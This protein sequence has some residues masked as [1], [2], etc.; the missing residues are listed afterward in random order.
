MARDRSAAAQGIATLLTKLNDPDPD[1]RFMQLSDLSNILHAPASEYIKS[2][3]HTAARIIEGLLK[4]LADQHGEVQNQALKCVGPLATR[5]PGEIMAPL[6]DKVTNLTDSDIDISIPN[7]ALRSL[8]SALPQ[9]TSAGITGQDVKDAYGAV[10]KVLIPRLVGHVILPSMKQ[11]KLPGTGLLQQQKDKGFSSDAVDV[12]IEIVRCYGPLLQEQEL[13]ELAKAVMNIIESP[14]A[15]GVVKKR[16]LAGMGALIVHFSDAQVTSFVNALTQSFQNPDITNEH[17]KYLVSTIGT[18]AKSTPAKF[19]PHLHTTAAY[20]LAPLSQGELN[21]NTEDSDADGEV[22]PELEELRETALIAVEA[23]VGSCP[24]E[25][26]PHVPE[27][28][29]AALRYLKYDPNVATFD[30]EEMGGTQDAG[31]DDGITEEP[32]DEDD[33]YGELDDED[34]FSDVDDLS[35]K[36]RR[37]AAK[38]LYTIINS[39]SMTDYEALFGNIA[40]VLIS[41][42]RNEREDT[43]RLEII[44]ATTALIRKT[45]STVSLLS[46]S[47]ANGAET[48]SVPSNSRKRR[49]QDSE[50]SQRDPELRGLVQS[51]SSP[52]IVTGPPPAGAHTDLASITPKLVQALT[53]LWKKASMSLKQAGVVMLKTLA[54]TRNGTLADYLQQLEDPTA[55]ALKPATGPG[56]GS[57]SGSSATVASLQIETLSMISMI[58]ETNSTTVLTPFVIALIPPVTQI[59][60]DKNFKVSS[61]ALATLEQFVKALTP[62]RLQTANQDHA[63]HLEKLYNVVI[64]RVTDNN[65]DLEVRHRAIQVF[66]VLIARTSGTR[67][68]SSQ[69]RTKGLGILSDRL[70]NETTRLASARAIGLVGESAAMQDNMGAAWVQEISLELGNQLRKSDRSLRGACL[71][72]IQYLALNPVTAAMYETSTITQLKTLLLPLISST[73]LHLLTPA[74]VVLAK[75]I[76]TNSAALVTEDLVEALCG[77]SRSRLEGAPLKAYLLVIKVIAE[78]GAGVQLMK[79]LLVVGLAG[80]TMVLGR[81]IGTL[82]VFSS[83]P[84]AVSVDSFLKELGTDADTNAKCL[85]LSVLGEVGFRMADKSPVRLEVFTQCLESPSDKVRLT[86]ATAL[87]SASS[88]H[89]SWLSTILQS[90]G[91]SPTKD[92][93]YLHSLKEIL[94]HASGN[95]IGPFGDQLWK[96]LFAAASAEDNRAVAAECIGRL[97]MIDPNY[98]AGLSKTLEDTNRVVRGTVISAFRFTL[99]SDNAGSQYNALLVKII[100]PMLKQMLADPDLTNRRLAVTTLNATIHN[101]PELIVADISTLLPSIIDDTKEKPELIRIVKIGPFTHKEDSGLDL[102][103]AAYNV[104]YELLDCPAAVPQLPISSIFDRIQDGIVDDAD[105]RTLC[106]LMLGRLITMDA[107]ETRRRLSQMAEKFKVVLGQKLKENAVKQEIEKVNEA[108]AAV[109]R[110]TLELDRAFPTAATD[111]SGEMVA[112]KG[113]IEFVKKEFAG[114][115]RSIQ[116]EGQ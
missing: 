79:G 7:T 111:G 103:K 108:N 88:S 59:A 8:I 98:V 64:D 100:S 30:D 72:A 83:T 68:L 39:L 14:Q 55:D 56:A 54:S 109:I 116:S 5:T 31:S 17:R 24:R 26:K 110:T 49:R 45:G 32:L 36:V 3:T 96:S 28:I 74:L 90:F 25:I 113:Y 51:R 89:V 71:E 18:L 16:A 105:I 91:R 85:A 53:R 33:E 40:P 62:P 2:D 58:T 43:V 65:A 27:A 95:D 92:Y 57:A 15:G 114:V 82:L 104:L 22:D 20:V 99:S 44:S 70:K 87:G 60:R 9:P 4:A 21:A 61:E 80:E 63:I 38:A 81:A 11:S 76:P 29:D 12:M 23:M 48:S 86:A 112:W 78:Q 69:A 73:D 1:I 77:V 10:S 93:L 102:R 97:A 107:D 6:I 75:I 13:V 46:S 84:L 35:W 42:L 19:G 94:Q 34:A 41:R 115:V 50:A 47:T 101:K 52:P 66:G 67:L 37:C 106:N